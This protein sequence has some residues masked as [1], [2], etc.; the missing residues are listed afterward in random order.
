MSGYKSLNVYQRAYHMAIRVHEIIQHYPRTQRYELA[1]QLWR[2][3]LSIPLNIAEGYGRKDSRNEF[4]HFLRNALGSCNEV[5]V[6]LEISND[7]GYLSTKD[8]QTLEVEYKI[9]SKQLYRLR[10]QY[11][12]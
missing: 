11:K 1:S 12:N 5:R 4:Q 2:S 7:L 8:Y 3:A 9:I 6:L 10:E